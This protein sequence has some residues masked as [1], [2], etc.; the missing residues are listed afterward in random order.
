MIVRRLVIL[1]LLLAAFGHDSLWCA[2]LKPNWTIVIPDR[3]YDL[4]MGLIYRY[5]GIANWDAT[6][7][8]I[9]FLAA[10]KHLAVRGSADKM[11]GAWSFSVQVIETNSGQVEQSAT[12]AAWSPRSELAVVAGGI[13][14]SDHDR[15]LFY[16]R[17]FKRLD[18]LFTYTPTQSLP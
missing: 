17:S 1:G 2:D 15:L 5:C 13:V 12:I 3:P 14:E 7:T 18:A 9:Y 10:N 16:S 11:E 4:G 6:H 8:L